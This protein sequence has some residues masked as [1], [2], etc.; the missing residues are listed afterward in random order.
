MITPTAL[1]LNATDFI[2]RGMAPRVI[3]HAGSGD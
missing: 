3:S 2:S 1:D